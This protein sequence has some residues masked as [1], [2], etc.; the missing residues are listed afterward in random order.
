MGLKTRQVQSEQAGS[1]NETQKA[2]DTFG[3]TSA[4]KKPEI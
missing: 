2:F 3:A 1:R 4:S